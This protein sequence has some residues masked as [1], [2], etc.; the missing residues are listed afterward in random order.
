M[1]LEEDNAM[2]RITCDAALREKLCDLAEP[3]ALCD[4]SGRVLARIVPALDLDSDSDLDFFRAPPLNKADLRR[5]RMQ[6]G[7]TYT[8]AEV[9]AHLESL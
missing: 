5:R 8:T 9:L 4:E 7:K 2:T 6:V 3:L 1:P